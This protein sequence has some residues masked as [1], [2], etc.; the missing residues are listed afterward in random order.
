MCVMLFRPKVDIPVD[1]WGYMEAPARKMLSLQK[2]LGLELLHSPVWKRRVWFSGPGLKRRSHLY[3]KEVGSSAESNPVLRAGRNELT[4]V[5]LRARSFLGSVIWDNCIDIFGKEQFDVA[6]V[7]TDKL[8]SRAN[9]D[10]ITSLI[11]PNPYRD[12][13]GKAFDLF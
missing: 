2:V 7:Q 11:F 6:D 9:V 1:V 5:C 4:G 3:P 8:C 12:N 13:K 10:S